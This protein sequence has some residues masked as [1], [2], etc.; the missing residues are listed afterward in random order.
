MANQKPDA[1]HFAD[2]GFLICA[3]LA[4]VAELSS[5]ETAGPTFALSD[6]ETTK[7]PIQRHLDPYEF[8]AYGFPRRAPPSRPDRSVVV[9]THRR[10]LLAPGACED[11]EGGESTDVGAGKAHV[12]SGG[13]RC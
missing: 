11:W 6:R 10:W 5:R 8:K 1:G 9:A 4:A 7:P 13:S 2:V 12:R 3:A